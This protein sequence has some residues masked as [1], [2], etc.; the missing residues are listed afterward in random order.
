[1]QSSPT[2]DS[3]LLEMLRLFLMLVVTEDLGISPRTATQTPSATESQEFC[4]SLH[5]SDQGCLSLA[6]LQIPWRCQILLQWGNCLKLPLAPAKKDL[7][8]WQAAGCC[9]CFSYRGVQQSLGGHLEQPQVPQM[10][11][12]RRKGI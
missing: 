3:F 5:D 8:L 4:K 11:F 7:L 9:S 1:M 10:G 12:D 2:T 6:P